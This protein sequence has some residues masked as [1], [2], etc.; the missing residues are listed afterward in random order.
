MKQFFY[1][2][3]MLH[4]VYACQAQANSKNEVKTHSSNSEHV[5]KGRQIRTDSLGAEEKKLDEFMLT[6]GLIRVTSLQSAIK[7]DLK[8]TTSD[9]FMHQVLYTRIKTA[10]LQKDVAERLVDCQRYLTTLDS[11][12]YLL[13]Y[14]AVRPVSVQRKMWRA[15]DSIPPKERVKF[16]SNPNNRSIHNYGAAVDLTICKS[17]GTPLD[18]GAGYDDIRKIAYPS[19][20]ATFVASGQLT[21]EH[22]ENR[23]LL[24]KVMNQ[25]GFSQLS[26]E[27]WHFN[28]CNRKVA[29]KKYRVLDKEP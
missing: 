29:A 26:T 12:L 14:D 11:G 9:N 23:N 7:I 18:M 1:F 10:Y 16:V 8:Y 13:V 24:R 28:A 27:W 22:I 17:D 15:L 6:Y 25:G 4:L 20:E 19:L 5:D 21:R 3:F 2:F